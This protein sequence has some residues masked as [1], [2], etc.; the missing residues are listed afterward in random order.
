MSSLSNKELLNVSIKNLT[1]L[2]DNEDITNYPKILRVVSSI[3]DQ[4]ADH[5]EVNLQTGEQVYKF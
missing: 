2:I 5:I 4:R 1:E 3:L